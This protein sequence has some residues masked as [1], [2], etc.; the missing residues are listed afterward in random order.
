[1]PNP[2]NFKRA[3]VVAALAVCLALVAAVALLRPALLGVEHREEVTSEF[4]T[5]GVQP[6]AP[7]FLSDDVRRPHADELPPATA[8]L[9]DSMPELERLAARG[10]AT[11]SC[12][13]AEGFAFCSQIPA[14]REDHSRWLA[15]RELA[16]N[17]STRNNAER[18][19]DF[20]KVFE[21]ELALREKRLRSA[22]ERCAGI[23]LAPP[24]ALVRHWRRAAL[25]GNPAAIRNYASGSAFQWN[26]I[27]DLV[28]ELQT[29][30][31]E[32]K[33][34]AFALA[35][36]GDLEMS[37]LLASA[38]SPLT[39]HGKPLLSQA[40]PEDGLVALALYRRASIA[41]QDVETRRDG[42]LLRRVQGEIEQLE[43]LVNETTAG[44][45]SRRRLDELAA[46]EPVKIPDDL[47]D[48]ELSG[49]LPEAA[50]D[51]CD[52]GSRAARID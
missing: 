5:V 46:W 23:T 22:Q 39:A 4:G 33:V 40:V 2:A 24:K 47:I 36:H 31:A 8:P 30:R 14:W 42:G 15:E 7:K 16:L 20:G 19:A 25:A 28:P 26:N 1:M 51:A 29:W 13:I 3:G 50:V 38:Y 41:L 32:A 17:I 18:V 45:S 43:A 48:V 27:V 21:T 11:A 49:G 9:N 37:L 35:R 52:G 12:R 44:V 6:A 10:N 34:L